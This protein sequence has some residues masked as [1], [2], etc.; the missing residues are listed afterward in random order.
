MRHTY[1]DNGSVAKGSV[2]LI[3]HALQ[4]WL[5]EYPSF[6]EI[7]EIEWS[8]D[9]GVVGAQVMYPRHGKSRSLQSIKNEILPLDIMG[10]GVDIAL[11][12]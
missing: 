3:G 8:P 6:H 12:W 9:H 5:P 7:H 2:I 10:T 4:G 11:W 1:L